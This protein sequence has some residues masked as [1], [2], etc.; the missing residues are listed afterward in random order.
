M[1]EALVISQILSW[2][3]VLALALMVLALLRQVGVP[4]ERIAPMGALT[5]DRGPKEGEAAPLFEVKDLRHGTP[6]KIGGARGRSMLLFF[7]SPTCPVCKKLLPIV[8]SIQQAENSWLDV[9]LTSDGEPVEHE[10]FIRV[11]HLEDFPYVLSADVGMTY[12]IGKLPY[13]VLIDDAGVI[14]AKGLLNTREHLESLIE[15]KQMGVPSIQQ[16]LQSRQPEGHDPHEH[17][18]E[19]SPDH[20]PDHEHDPAPD[21][22]HDHA[23]GH[24]HNHEAQP[25]A[26]S[27]KLGRK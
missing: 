8:K 1:L 2:V 18:Q 4:H 17:S 12:R 27:R 5:L 13:G 22:A 19:H 9:V 23:D 26:A 10:R 15:A 11:Q 21:H 7:L 14:R 20:S 3:L 24:A 16:F 6:L 25:L